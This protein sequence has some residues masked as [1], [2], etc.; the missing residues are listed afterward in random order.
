VWINGASVGSTGVSFGT[1]DVVTLAVDLGG[2][3]IR[4]AKNGGALSTAVNIAALSTVNLSPAANLFTP[5]D[6][7]T[8][9]GSTPHAYTGFTAWDGGGPPPPQTIVSIS[10]TSVSLNTASCTDGTLVTAL[11]ATMSNG[12]SPPFSGTWSESGDAHFRV[13]T[14]T[15][16]LVCNGTVP[17]QSTPYT[18]TVTATPSNTAIAAKSQ[19]I[20]VTIQ[21]ITPVISSINLSGGTSFA[22]P[23]VAGHTIDTLSASCSAGSCAGATFALV[24]QT[25]C[26]STGNA[27]F[28]VSGTNL[29]IA[30]SPPGPAQIND[31][32]PRSICLRARV[33]GASDFFQSFTLVGL[34]GAVPAIAANAG[35]NTKAADFTWSDTQWADP[36]TQWLDCVVDGSQDSK[37]WHVGN[38]GITLTNFPCNIHQVVDSFDGST[39][40]HFQFLMAYNSQGMTGQFNTI[41]MQTNSQYGGVDHFS[42]SLPMN[43]YREIMYRTGP[44]VCGE[45]NAGGPQGVWSWSAPYT[46]EV[47]VAELWQSDC[48]Y[49]D[50]GGKEWSENGS[51]SFGGWQSYST[52]NLPVGWIQTAYHKYAVLH[53]SDGAGT[54]YVCWFVDDVLQMPGCANASS[55]GSG[56]A[57]ARRWIIESLTSGEPPQSTDLDMYVKYD[58]VYACSGWATGQCFG[59]SPPFSGTQDGNPLIYFI[60]P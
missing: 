37:I 53:T 49:G 10:P 41:G 33:V 57:S 43:Y 30:P 39:V 36:N 17:A 8:F 52:N 27:S 23:A 45:H 22:I 25:G 50:A 42:L 58:R 19:A 28:A 44:A 24:T 47:D 4:A 26:T 16:N 54:F 55:V 9:N 1:S 20:S 11:T 38:P 40:M 59:S 56:Y 48:G 46:L 34:S 5:T 18:P 15:A 12:D 14:G 13:P 31:T 2:K 21:T 51:P 32:T 6:V 29:N 60:H 3:T 7:V 35:F